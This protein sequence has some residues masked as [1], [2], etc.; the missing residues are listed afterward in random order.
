MAGFYIRNTK[1]QSVDPKQKYSI[2]A[3]M[4][5]TV[6]GHSMTAMN[7]RALAYGI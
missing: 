1:G 7:I 5:A 2:S 6:N 4:T 3:W